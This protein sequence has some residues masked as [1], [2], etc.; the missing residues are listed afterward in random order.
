M[1]IHSQAVE[2]A[3]EAGR[4]RLTRADEPLL[5]LARTLARQVDD[6]GSEGPGTRLAGTYLTVVRTLMARFGRLVPDERT[7]EASRALA[8]LRSANASRCK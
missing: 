2:A 7:D 4:G 3:I 1:G 5:E 8:R 6:A